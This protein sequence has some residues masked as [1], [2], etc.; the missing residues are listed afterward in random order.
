MA[1]KTIVILGG[2]IGG[3]VAARE[4]RR[5]LERRHRIVLIDRN[6]THSFPPSYLWVIVGWRKP[7]AISRPLSLLANHGIE[8]RQADVTRIDTEKRQIETQQ[9]KIPYDH[10]VIALGAE[11]SGSTVPGYS[12]SAETFY[13]LEGATRL[14]RKLE[15]FRGGR[16]SIVIAELPYK[17]PPAP[18]EAA[19]LIESY[20]AR[21]GISVKISVHT[22][23]SSPL[24]VAGPGGSSALRQL[25][26]SRRIR[27]FTKR[28]LA[29]VEDGGLRFEDGSQA[30][31]DLI[32]GVPPHTVPDVILRSGLA[33]DSGWI[34]VDERTL[35]TREKDAY[36]LGDV[37]VITLPNGSALPKAGVFAYNQAEIVAHN[38]ATEINGHGI[39]KKF[40][41]NGYCFLETGNGR[42]GYITGNFF[43]KPGP[44]V[45]MH[46]PSVAYHWGKVTFE[47]YWL[48]RWF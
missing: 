11:L 6:A 42:A 28:K 34:P 32:I 40:V 45:T 16:I 18:Y 1:S 7:E 3:I 5:H 41:G 2:G 15:E 48:W 14:R 10:L 9:E 39:F 33:G 46:E 17:C 47:K 22:P 35:R 44:E 21:K 38:I 31:Y 19:L 12:Q 25:L 26:E 4:L 13:T 30:G 37:T 36:A 43:A 27:L 29:A 23:E 8:F 20:F 24:S